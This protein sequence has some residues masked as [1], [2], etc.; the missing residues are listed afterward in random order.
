MMGR[1]GSR[2]VIKC[3]R[4]SVETQM[5]GAL[6]YKTTCTRWPDYIETFT[7]AQNNGVS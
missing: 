7:C 6:T 4:S 2:D 3:A 1:G 5:G